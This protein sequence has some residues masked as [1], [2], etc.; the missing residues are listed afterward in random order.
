MKYMM[1]PI[2]QRARL[3]GM[4]IE[5]MVVIVVVFLAVIPK[6]KREYEITLEEL[7]PYISFAFAS[8]L[9]RNAPSTGLKS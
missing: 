7:H 8:A 6:R 9:P 1:N 3:L 2:A 4:T 5:N